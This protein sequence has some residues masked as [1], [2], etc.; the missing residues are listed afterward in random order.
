MYTVSDN[1][2][3][4]T[5]ITGMCLWNKELRFAYNVSAEFRNWQQTSTTEFDQVDELNETL[6]SL[7]LISAFFFW[8]GGGARGMTF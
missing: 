6:I 2:S 3:Y 4:F 7:P 5:Y 1:E 8:G